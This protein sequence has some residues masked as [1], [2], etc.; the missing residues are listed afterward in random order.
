MASI[1]KVMLS[2]FNILQLCDLI[3]SES[4]LNLPDRSVFAERVVFLA[5]VN[6][7]NWRYIASWSRGWEI[8]LFLYATNMLEIFFIQ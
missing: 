7:H 4:M 3:V 8:Y 6:T 5:N 1:L 2:R